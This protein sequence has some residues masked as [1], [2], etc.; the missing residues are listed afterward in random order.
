MNN[1]F[2]QYK[3]IILESPNLQGFKQVSNNLWNFRCPIC[4]DSVKNKNKRRGYFYLRE[5]EY[6]FHCH[7]CGIDKSFLNF[8]YEVNSELYKEYKKECAFNTLKTNKNINE[9]CS[10]QSKKIPNIKIVSNNYLTPLTELDNEHPAIVYVRSRCIPKSKYERLFWTEN[11]NELVSSTISNSYENVQKPNAGIVFTIR[12]FD[13]TNYPIIGYQI[14]SIDK[15]IPKN[16]RFMIC[17]EQ[18]HTGVFGLDFLDESKQI[19]VVEGPFD[20]LFLPNSIAVFTSGIWR[21]KLQNAIYINDCEPR[22]KQIVEQI[23]K[24]INI[25]LNVTLLPHK[26]NSLD[27]NDI[28]CKYKLN[29]NEL[30]DLIKQNT[31]NGLTAKLKL[32]KWRL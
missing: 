29:E 6:R 8:L 30:V 32:S 22:N 28:V 23:Q 24:C 27:I 15:N 13:A 1:T 4:G 21:V 11:F 19:Y 12:A 10:K 16:K 3:Y 9:L 20:S 18:G 17:K 31:F 25:G 26:Y 5:G 2:I 14:R 7:N